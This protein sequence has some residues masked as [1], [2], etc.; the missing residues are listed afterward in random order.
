MFWS[1]EAR[2]SPR[3]QGDIG[4]RAAAVWLL[5]QPHISV[6]VPFGHSPDTDL[7]ALIGDRLTRVQVKTSTVHIKN[8]RYQVSLATR[9]GNQS[10]NGL[11]KRFSSARCEFLF[12]LLADGRQWFIPSS[13]VEGSSSIVVGGP[14]YAAYEVDRGRPFEVMQAA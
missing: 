9:G 14:K 12:V 8:G 1:M 3:E 11:V 2:I 6:F 4:E 7:I 10:W 13:A 5:R